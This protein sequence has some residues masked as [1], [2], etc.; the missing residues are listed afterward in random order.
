MQSTDPG[1]VIRPWQ[2]VLLALAL[3]SLAT[4][5]LI[6]VLLICWAAAAFA[7]TG[8][9][10]TPTADLLGTDRFLLGGGVHLAVGMLLLLFVSA[11]APELR[12]RILLAQGSN[13]PFV[14]WWRAAWLWPLA[15][16]GFVDLVLLPARYWMGVA[17][18]PGLLA[19]GLL[20]AGAVMIV[21]LF[22]GAW[23]F[24]V[25]AITTLWR[26]GRRSPMLTGALVAVAVLMPALGYANI[27]FLDAIAQSGAVPVRREVTQLC[28][29]PGMGALCGRPA[30][31]ASLPP[32]PFE[33]RA[34]ADSG[35]RP[36]DEPSDHRVMAECMELLH[37]TNAERQ[38]SYAA[39]VT[40]AAALL[41]NRA[42]AL[43]AVQQTLL[44][45]CLQHEQQSIRDLYTYFIRSV[46]NRAFSGRSRRWCSVPIE[47]DSPLTCPA[48]TPEELAIQ[49]ERVRVAE[50]AY[51]GLPERDAM[52]IRLR[53]FEDLDYPDIARQLNSTEVAIRQRHSRALH[54]LQGAV[55]RLCQ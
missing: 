44:A 34:V 10:L 1:A 46:I 49:A 8:L 30:V 27:S 55:Q 23:R 47:E 18:P 16:I 21:M 41:R 33:T 14:P 11:G 4:F 17:V 52:V 45:V 29:Q 15:A 37:Q 38:Y 5:V 43:D 19:G 3:A 39:M 42:D 13:P 9:A 36:S 20:A 32:S 40:R 22:V 31:A 2:A 24:G 54:S 53:D 35:P 6:P 7:I 28:D 51:C 26:H 25:G 48:P 50:Q 12:R